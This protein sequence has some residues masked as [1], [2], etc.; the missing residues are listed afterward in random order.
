MKND[1]T[2]V[3]V[4]FYSE[5]I[6][7]KYIKKLS[8]FKIII[9]ENSKNLFLKKKLKNEKNIKVFVSKKNLGFGASINFAK[10]K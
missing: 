2:I 6:I 8:G 3:L 5:K 1:V 10:K 4:S 7:L 9:V